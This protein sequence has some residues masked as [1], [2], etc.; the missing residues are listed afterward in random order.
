[1]IDKEHHKSVLENNQ[2][3]IKQNT[4]L[5]AQVRHLNEEVETFKKATL[6]K[7]R[8]TMQLYDRHNDKVLA[9]L[10]DNNLVNPIHLENIAKLFP[11]KVK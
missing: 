4:Q 8:E 2:K 1:M 5:H 6:E 3:L 7:V 10:K 11:I 9:Y